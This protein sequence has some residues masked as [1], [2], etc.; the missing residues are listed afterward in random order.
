MKFFTLALATAAVALL[1]GCATDGKS[2]AQEKPG[3][4]ITYSCEGKRSFQIRF[5]AEHGTARIRSHEGS[6]ELTK[7]SRGLYRDPDGEWVLTLTGASGTE[8]VH[9]G[10]A[11]YKNC[12]AR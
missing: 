7:G 3:T 12:A 1:V 6:A 8:L 4:F 9:R 2:V 10:V 5:D 11:R